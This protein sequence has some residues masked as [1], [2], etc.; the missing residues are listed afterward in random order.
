M[1]KTV[2]SFLIP[3]LLSLPAVISIA[4]KAKADLT[5]CNRSSEK[6]Y[7]ATAW[8]SKGHWLSSG[9]IHVIPG[10]C[11]MVLTGDMSDNNAYLNVSDA[12]WVP[13]KLNTN[14]SFQFC[15]KESGFDLIDADGACSLGMI[16][17]AFY[18][19]NSGGR[20]DY[21]VNLD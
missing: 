11:E 10:Q 8:Y 21:Q 20:Y 7:V 15:V 5:V 2:N 9:W 4:P 1:I 14:D 17:K 3:C 13:W 16:P 12:S 19:I 6:A 18:K